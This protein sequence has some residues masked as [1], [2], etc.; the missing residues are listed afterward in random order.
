[1]LIGVIADERTKNELLAQGVQPGTDIQWMDQPAIISGAAAYIHLLFPENPGP[2]SAWE[3][4]TDTPVIINDVLQKKRQLPSH[5]IRLN[6]WPTFL[7]R[8]LVE[9]AG[10]DPAIKDKAAAIFSAFNKSVEW[11]PD[12]P[13]FIS[14]RI[15][16]MIINEAY[17]TL[18]EAVSTKE[19]IDIAMKLG[20]NYPY[21][22]FEWA[23]LIG[24]KN[25]YSL[26]DKL[27]V[28]H[29]RYKPSALLLKEAGY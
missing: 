18:Q 7:T 11:V 22:P 1:M 12:V 26:L 10:S 29:S 17:Y 21:G 27:C 4:L 15:I 14:T 19:E 16:S 23:Q 6:A 24:L 28:N 8:P 9:V 5:F 2:L 3:I 25:I 20:T 13:G